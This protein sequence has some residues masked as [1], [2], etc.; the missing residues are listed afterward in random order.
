MDMVWNTDLP[1]CFTSG[2]AHSSEQKI[3]KN[4]WL[5]VFTEFLS[6]LP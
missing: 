1:L 6:S 2:M 5:F 4:K 3:H